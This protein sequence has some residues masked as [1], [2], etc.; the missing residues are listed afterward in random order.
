MSMTWR[1]RVSLASLAVA[2][3]FMTAYSTP[4][5]SKAQT[6]DLTLLSDDDLKA[7]VIRLER[8]RCLG[9]CPAYALTI[10]GD[11]RVEYVD[12]EKDGEKRPKKGTVDR[13][14][15]KALV[16]EFTRTKFLS[17]PDYLLEKCTCRLCTDLPSAIT[18]IVVRGETHRVRHDYG[19]GCAPKA[20]FKLESAIDKA[21]NVEQWT[22][23]TSQKG[24][25]GTTCFQP[26]AAVK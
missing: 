24:P 26:K 13:S 5:Q 21:A 17:L 11:G 1:L 19:C 12:K 6:D 25:F 8:T 9:T 16:S 15:V 22:G 2:L 20:L 4:I 23:D 18:E 14:A 10:H 7:V 3:A